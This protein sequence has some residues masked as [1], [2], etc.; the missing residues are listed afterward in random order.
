MSSQLDLKQLLSL[1]RKKLWIVVLVAVIG[2]VSA[3]AYSVW[4]KKPV[5]QAYTKLIVNST[6]GQAGAFKLDLNMINT[7][8]SLINTYKE[9]I[10]TPSIMD[11]V[12]EKHPELDLTSEQLMRNIRFSSVNGTQVVTVSYLD[13]DYKRAAN[14]VNSVSYVFQQQI[15]LIMQVDNVYILHTAD[16][17]KQPTPVKPET[18]LNIAIGAVVSLMLG[19]MLVLLIEYFDDNLRNEAS[20]ERHLGLPTLSVIPNIRQSD[21]KPKQPAAAVPAE[22]ASNPKAISESKGG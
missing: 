1:I 20:V 9:I 14:I 7:N 8:L 13:T 3:G 10:R 12:L 16:P 2:T 21:L 5:Y 17:G 22:T 4:I 11:I 6:V 19:I 18:K 15:P